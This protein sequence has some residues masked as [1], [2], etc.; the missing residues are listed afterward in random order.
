[1]IDRSDRAQAGVS[2]RDDRRGTGVVRVGLVGA[3][4][5][6]QPHPRRQCRW[7]IDDTLA[8]RDELLCQQRTQTPGSFDRPRARLERCRESQ[9]PVALPTIRGHAQLADQVLG[10]VEHRR[11]V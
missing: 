7:H 4:R 2:Q 5:V 10:V 8:R 3:T 6:Q 9:Q 1:V 11:G